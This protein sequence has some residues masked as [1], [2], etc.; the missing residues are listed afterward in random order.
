MQKSALTSKLLGEGVVLGIIGSV[1]G[2]AIG[3]VM[4]GAALKFVGGDLGGGYFGSTA[5]DLRFSPAAALLFLGFGI[6][7]AIIGSYAPAR[8]AAKIAPAEALKTAGDPVDP[9][10]PPR[11]RPSLILVL[12]GAALAFLPAV[13]RLPLFGYLAVALVLAG[14]IT[15]MPWLART[16]LA[17]LA[18]M[19][20]RLPSVELALGRL[21]GA[22]SQAATALGGIV[23]STGLMIAM[24]VM[25]TS[26]RGSVE[27]W[28]DSF[29]SAD[30]YAA[31][32][33]NEPLFDLATQERVASAP[34]IASVAFSKSVPV[35]IDPE[36]PSLMLVVRPVGGPG[37]A[38]PLIAEADRPGGGVRLWLSEPAARLYSLEAGDRL[39]LPIGPAGG[40]VQGYVAGVWR[41][42]AR[43]QGAIVMDSRDYVA[44]TGDTVRSEAAIEL[45]PGAQIS[46]VSAAIEERLPP[47]V[48]GR[49]DFAEPA[50]LRAQALTLFDRSFAITYVLE[51]IA[52]VI[53]LAGVAATI[54][55]QTIARIRE[56]G[57]L[58]HIG[59]TRR[60]II[61]MLAGE[62]ALLGVIGIAAG[63]ALG[64]ALSQILIHVINPQSFNWTMT[65]RVPW[66]LLLAVA[67]AL[68]ATSAGTAVLAG[69]RA[70]SGDALRAVSED[71]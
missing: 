42:Y 40:A 22:P 39:D 25:V 9:R 11:W 55:A 65:T 33:T 36:L 58:R 62:G 37:Y 47:S 48:A 64:L 43:Q 27:D 12:A 52:I 30:L 8:A 20:T 17:P 5:P 31:A 54:S 70:L 45:E 1:A 61:G 59:T 2:L 49:I 15:A 34:G 44:L 10:V 7:T 35:A 56:F 21:T 68:V 32:A 23:A 14:G 51:A 24:A 60:Q 28:L 16:L 26:F 29:L 38:L 71:W 57:M 50:T 6:T 66:L 18:R 46:T 41:D 19:D 13:N 63:C 67:A 3:Y 53:G 69:R 4:A